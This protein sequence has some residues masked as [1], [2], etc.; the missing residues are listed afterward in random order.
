MDKITYSGLKYKNYGQIETE[1]YTAT[2]EIFE[3]GRNVKKQRRIA[4][5]DRVI[6]N[7]PVPYLLSDREVV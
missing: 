2:E 1:V 3:P 6:G 4:A 5:Y 7:M